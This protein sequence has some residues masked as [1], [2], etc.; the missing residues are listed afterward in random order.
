MPASDI[1]TY[2]L[3]IEFGLT[4]D[5]ATGT[6]GIVEQRLGKV[7]EQVSNLASKSLMSMKTIT[8]QLNVT[9]SEMA[10]QY[11]RI[12]ASSIA[13]LKPAK[14]SAALG[15]ESGKKIAD[16]GVMLRD[17]ILKTWVDITKILGNKEKLLS[18]ESKIIEKETVQMKEVNKELTGW[19]DNVAHATKGLS[20]YLKSLL[21]VKSVVMEAVN[22][23]EMFKNANYR[24]Y[25]SQS[26][27]VG[28]AYELSNQYGIMRK[29]AMEAMAQ[30]GNMKIP[31]EMMDKMLETNV[32]FNRLS[33]ASIQQTAAWQ[34]AMVGLGQ[35][36]GDIESRMIHMS[37]AMRRFGLDT[38][39]VTAILRM[40]EEQAEDLLGTYG[41][42][43]TGEI[44]K[45]Q[46]AVA[47]FA[48]EIGLTSKVAQA[49]AESLGQIQPHQWQILGAA[50]GKS[51]AQ[52]Q[53]AEGQ[54]E[55]LAAV[56]ATYAERLRNA[57]DQYARNAIKA[58]MLGIYGAK[59]GASLHAMSLQQSLSTSKVK[60]GAAA[61]SLM[62]EALKGHIGQVENLDEIYKESN[63][64]IVAQL[65]LLKNAFYASIGAIWAKFEPA[66]IMFLQWINV[67]VQAV[68]GIVGKITAWLEAMGP[69]GTV[70]KTVAAGVMVAT[71]AFLSLLLV[72]NIFSA[73]SSFAAGAGK[74]FGAMIEAALQGMARGLT[75]VAVHQ[76]TMLSL[77][78]LF[79]SMGLGAF[80]FALAV[81]TLAQTGWAGAAALVGLAAV[82]IVFGAALLYVGTISTATQSGLYALSVAFIAVGA[83]ALLFAL[84]VKIIAEQGWA[85]AAA[86][87]GLTVALIAMGVAIVALGAAAGLVAP[88]MA[89]FTTA[90]YALALV[91]VAVGVAAI[92]FALAVSIVAQR[93]R[94]GAIAV[95]VLTAALVVMMVTLVI[96]AVKATAF[97][98][99][100]VIL[101]VVLLALAVAAMILAVAIGVVGLAIVSAGFGAKMFAEAV[102]MIADA[103]NAGI[104]ALGGLVMAITTIIMTLALIAIAVAPAIPLLLSLGLALMMIGAAAALVGLS[105]YLFSLGIKNLN[106]FGF[107]AAMGIIFITVALAFMILVI[108]GLAAAGVGAA[109]GLF[110]LALVLLA[111]G[112][113]AVL[114]GVAAL[115]VA[116]SIQMIAQEGLMGIAVLTALSVAF[117]IFIAALVA[118]ALAAMPVIPAIYAIAV[119]VVAMGA[120]ML[121]AGVGVYLFGLGLGLIVD[122][123][124][125]LTLGMS[126]RLALFAASLAATGIILA[127]AA[128]PIMIAAVLLVVAGAL[129]AVAMLMILSAAE[130]TSI[131]GKLIAQG[132][133]D[134][135]AGSAALLMAGIFMSIGASLLLIGGSLLIAAA[136][137]ILTAGLMLRVMT[138]PIV[139]ASE[140]LLPAA[141]RFMVIGAGFMA[142][143][144]GLMSGAQMMRASVSEL[145]AAGKELGGV[146][147]ELT[148]SLEPMLA[149]AELARQIAYPIMLLGYAVRMGASSLLSGA[150][151]LGVATGILRGPVDELYSEAQWL[152]L[153]A[154]WILQ[155]GSNM[156]SGAIMM[157]LAA[158]QFGAAMAGLRRSMMEPLGMMITLFASDA[159]VAA[160]TLFDTL[161]GILARL[162]S[163]SDKMTANSSAI[164]KAFRNILPTTPLGSIGLNLISSQSFTTTRGKDSAE[165]FQERGEKER[166]RAQQDKML[167]KLDNVSS[168]ISALV[169]AVNNVTGGG[170]IGNIKPVIENIE[171]LLRDNLPN[172]ARSQ[173][174]GLSHALNEWMR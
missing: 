18:D 100:I 11:D 93:G 76:V 95:L 123:A 67:F 57:G 174:S 46:V 70:L 82:M 1:N 122:A 91:I 157:T 168:G 4:A 124:A 106:D 170:G 131:A 148:A 30:L 151:I 150:I 161:D 5:Q 50:A 154:N 165:M 132:G 147:G 35:S 2:A 129:F 69:V 118:G 85:G 29:E 167:E 62:V 127:A 112:V 108:G 80:L 72:L 171:Q 173:N 17:K 77:A 16:E 166:S 36:S 117:L 7:E 74:A 135:M 64:T 104:A 87:L 52:M 14:E 109:A 143:G 160:I 96:L 47:A 84:A 134:L 23:T 53:T 9:L 116:K 136:A 156:F 98:G 49:A 58:E 159:S 8:D 145:R 86:L 15:V 21:D 141:E 126:V 120:G 61:Q 51:A 90:L 10:K 162:E 75:A 40:Q 144:Q 140:K 68:T 163:Y 63:N 59:A 56:S 33:G 34:K 142:G 79:V 81:K 155:A 13:G 78:A 139:S 137:V 60:D 133:P 66:V 71:V 54:T 39:D 114:V 94:D 164:A 172:M 42:K 101:V 32:K 28:R 41:E 138:G 130:N 44:Q 65:G 125:K 169:T 103:G 99:P 110:P 119:A 92:L 25:G 24:L 20:M 153:A 22:A 26:E 19:A 152:N 38:N 3:S 43:R 113:A 158:Y 83:S 107:G 146:A 73:A 48:K 88:G 12:G 105:F 37:V 111:I 115:L 31:I 27:L 102:K 89:L 97:I 6:L 45:S 55:A 149:V 128:Q 121:L